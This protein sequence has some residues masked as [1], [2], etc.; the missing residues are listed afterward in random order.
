MRRA[1]TVLVVLAL[2]ACVSDNATP[3][4]AAEP[5]T[6][7][8]DSTDSEIMEHLYQAEMDQKATDALTTLNIAVGIEAPLACPAC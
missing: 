6:L 2:G 7:S 8:P 4:P 3:P 5:A 1:W